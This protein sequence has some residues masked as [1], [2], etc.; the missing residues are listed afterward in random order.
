MLLRV[1]NDDPQSVSQLHQLANDVR[2]VEVESKYIDMTAGVRNA[3]VEK[4]EDEAVALNP[5]HWYCFSKPLVSKSILFL[6]FGR[7][8]TFSNRSAYACDERNP[9]VKPTR[10]LSSSVAPA[11]QSHSCDPRA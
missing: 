2:L 9:R 8:S 10:N 6:P 1:V 3:L 7:M 11:K 5:S 4:L